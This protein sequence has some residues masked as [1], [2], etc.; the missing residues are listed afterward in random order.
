MLD[1]YPV[2]YLKTSLLARIDVKLFVLPP[3]S[4]K[5][6]GHVER[7]QRAHTGEF[8]EVTHTSFEILELKQALLKWQEVYNTIHPHQA[9]G[10]LTPKEFLELYQQ[11]R[12]KE[13]V[14]LNMSTSTRLDNFVSCCY[15]YCRHVSIALRYPSPQ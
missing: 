12:R 13:Q 11:N 2:W 5:L 15:P 9:L 14:S 4:A 8:Y 1:L 3:R 10:Y 6:N 7:A